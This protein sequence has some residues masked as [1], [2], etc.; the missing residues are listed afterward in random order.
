MQCAQSQEQPAEAERAGNVGDA[1]GVAG[2]AGY[3]S[4]SRVLRQERFDICNWM[5]G[6]LLV[7]TWTEWCG[8]ARREKSILK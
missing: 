1:L 2:G 7:Q 8:E 3:H 6:F 5:P 4:K